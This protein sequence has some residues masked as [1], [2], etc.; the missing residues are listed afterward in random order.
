MCGSTTFNLPYFLWMISLTPMIHAVF[1]GENA[2]SVCEFRSSRLP[3]MPLH[4]AELPYLLDSNAHPVFIPRNGGSNMPSISVPYT[5]LASMWAVFRHIVLE[6]K[7]FLRIGCITLPLSIMRVSMI[8][9]G[10]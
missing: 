8:E 4:L 6:K 3:S 1:L 7:L 9:A 10:F 2:I 5:I